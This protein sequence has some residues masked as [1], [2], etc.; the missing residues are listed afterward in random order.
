MGLAANLCHLH[1]N[2]FLQNTKGGRGGLLLAG[3]A[4]GSPP[5]RPRWPL[6]RLRPPPPPALC[7]APALRRTWS[8]VKFRRLRGTR[9]GKQA[10]AGVV[11]GGCVT[12]ETAANG[13]PALP[14]GAEPSAVGAGGRGGAEASK[15]TR[16]GPGLSGRALGSLP[17]QD[18]L[19]VICTAQFGEHLD[20]ASLA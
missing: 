8:P 20:G 15:K 3:G 17:G 13:R 16:A 6:R 11:G 18:A 1:S 14:A 7:P 12:M 9:V 2:A 5:P 19:A 10:A 4:R